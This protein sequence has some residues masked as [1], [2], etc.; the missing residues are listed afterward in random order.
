MGGDEGHGMKRACAEV[1]PLL[2]A[3]VDGEASAEERA[4][5]DRHLERCEP[6][7]HH[8][9]RE[10]AVRS[11][12]QA[13]RHGLTACASP[14]L[15]TRCAAAFAPAPPARSAHHAPRTFARRTW[16]P[17]SF[18][19]TLLL[20]VSAVFIIGLNGSVEALA[21]QLA[22]DHVKC[23]QLSPVHGTVD[24][25][26]AGQAWYQHYGWLLR[27]PRSQ[28]SEELELV[29]VRRCLSTEGITA[30]LM[31]RWR[32]TPLSVYVLNGVPKSDTPMETRLSSREQQLS[33]IGQQEIIWSAGGRTYAV[34]GKGQ[35]RDLERVAQYVRT[36]A[37]E[38]RYPS[39]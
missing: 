1:E 12:L 28:P 9:V 5:V 10:R 21:T 30:H 26:A 14:Q 39:K 7:R 13:R 2:A 23:F 36:A 25:S 37:S 31:Y 15:R 4:T 19:A 27:V 8:E 11:V 22:M 6:C 35:R 32:G 16:L 38:T 24:A 29:D 18:A 17:L 20:A 34:V 33:A 3:Y